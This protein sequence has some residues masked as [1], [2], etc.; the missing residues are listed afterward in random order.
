MLA[1]VIVLALATHTEGQTLPIRYV[2]T[3]VTSERS[4][5]AAL[6]ALRRSVGTTR[7]QTWK[8]QD[9][10]GVKRTRASVSVW[11]LPQSVTYRSWVSGLWKG[12]LAACLKE[13]QWRTI[14][15]I[16][17]RHGAWVEAMR[18]VQRI[19][20]DTYDWLNYISDREGCTGRTQFDCTLVWYGNRPWRGYHIGDDFLGADTVIGPMQFRYSTF[21]PYWRAAKENLRARGF[22]IPAFKMPAAGGDPKYA[23]WLSPMGQALTA[24]YMKWAGREGCHWCLD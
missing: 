2:A 10:L 8:C 14:P 18:Y 12:R 6:V 5:Q 20:P 9:Q 1:L 11:A 4:Q 7:S 15:D 24:G 19:Y 16:G 13:V 21:A 22:I 23:A 17:W 3:D